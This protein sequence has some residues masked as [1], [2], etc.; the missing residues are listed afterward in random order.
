MELLKHLVS[1]DRSINRIERRWKRRFF[2]FVY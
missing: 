1:T 2:P